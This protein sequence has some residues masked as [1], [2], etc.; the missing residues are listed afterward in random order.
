MTQLLLAGSARFN[1]DKTCVYAGIFGPTEAKA[2]QRLSDESILVV[3]FALPT[4]QGLHKE[5]EAIIRRTLEPIIVRSQNPMCAIEVTLQV[6][7]D[8][9]SLLAA[10]VNA[11]VSA[12]VDA[13]VPMCGQAA[14]VTCAIS[15]DGSIMLDPTRQEEAGAEACITLVLDASGG[16]ITSI[17]TGATPP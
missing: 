1:F 9:G 6:V 17:C 12:L 8:D 7:N 16:I 3:N 15:P 14:A 2:N 13:G 5:N 11:A 10:S 4:G